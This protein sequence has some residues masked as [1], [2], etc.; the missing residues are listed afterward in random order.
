MVFGIVLV[1]ARA[2]ARE[3]EFGARG[4]TVITSNATTDISWTSYDS[5]ATFASGNLGP[6]FDYF[7]VKNFSLGIDANAGFNVTHGFNAFGVLG[8]TTESSTNFTARGGANI[9]FDRWVSWWLHF[10]AE[11]AWYETTSAAG[12]WRRRRA[13][14]SSHGGYRLM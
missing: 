7:V 13:R 9:R 6:S 11:V 10:D 14:R 8:Q 5:G 4:Q 3:P 1:T 2:A 12:S